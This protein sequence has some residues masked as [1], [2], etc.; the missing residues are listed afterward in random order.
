M[1]SVVVPRLILAV[2]AGFLLPAVGRAQSIT[3]GQVDMFDPP[4]ATSPP[5]GW[6]GS[7]PNITVVGGGQGGANDHYLQLS[8]TGSFG[9]GSRLV[10]FNQA[11]W[12]GDY[13]AAGVNEIQIDLI[14]FSATAVAMRVALKDAAG[15]SDGYVSTTPV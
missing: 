4:P 5:L 3:F 8:S 10:M 12:H 6:S 7:A 2:V 1:R 15:R 13:T 11:Q 14:N 9:A